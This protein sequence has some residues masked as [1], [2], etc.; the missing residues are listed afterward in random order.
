[1]TKNILVCPTSKLPLSRV[2]FATGS[3][4]LGGQVERAG[5]MHT[6]AGVSPKEALL[7]SDN[8]GLYPVIDGIPILIAPEMHASLGTFERIDTSLDPYREA[9]EEMDFYNGWAQREDQS[10]TQTAPYEFLQRVVDAKETFPEPWLK[11]LDA[12][13]DL[14]AQQDAYSHLAPVQGLRALQVGG[15][16]IHAVKFLIA[17]ARESWLATPMLGEAR[18][19]QRLAAEF[20]VEERLHCIVAIGEELPFQDGS[21][22][23]VFCGGC[24]HHTITERSLAEIART[25]TE[26]GRFAA[27]EP[28]RAPMYGIGTKVFGKREPGVNCRPI[29]AN[30]AR[31][32][33]ESFADATVRHHGALSRY[34]LLALNKLRVRPSVDIIRKI[35]ALD[36]RLSYALGPLKSWGS[37]VAM[38]GTK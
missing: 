33:Y 36:D 14:D 5:L 3:R 38:L 24:L 22:D 32:L 19:A 25:L 35:S 2:S 28:W 18:F 29:D 8:G 1:M 30:R 16:G 23:R 20:G 13:Y 27:V 26:G 37:S 7:R 4:A 21:F 31:P 6:P 17:G 34:P 11:W 15:R 10:I 12:T 9:Y